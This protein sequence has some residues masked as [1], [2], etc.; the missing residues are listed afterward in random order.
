MISTPNHRKIS[1]LLLINPI[2]SK[3]HPKKPSKTSIHHNFAA[4]RFRET[5]ET[6]ETHGIFHFKNLPWTSHSQ[7]SGGVDF[8][9]LYALDFEASAVDL[10]S[11][12]RRRL[13]QLLQFLVA[14]WRWEISPPTMG[15][16]HVEQRK[17]WGYNW[18]MMVDDDIQFGDF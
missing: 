14:N 3:I 6:T 16:N 12:G 8:T 7:A 9:L 10:Q 13:L 1:C 2:S 5:T 17:I 15:L 18:W 4:P 11:A